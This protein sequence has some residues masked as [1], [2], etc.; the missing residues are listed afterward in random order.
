M[1]NRAAAK[2]IDGSHGFRAHQLAKHHQRLRH[3]SS[4]RPKTRPHGRYRR[5]CDAHCTGSCPLAVPA[6]GGSMTIMTAQR[7]SATQAKG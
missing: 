4:G 3:R 7:R 1:T 5:N 2:S 6:I